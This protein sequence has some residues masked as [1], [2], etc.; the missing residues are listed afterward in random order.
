MNNTKG[1]R[2]VLKNGMDVLLNDEEVTIYPGAQGIVK[3][4]S[5]AWINLEDVDKIVYT[6][7]LF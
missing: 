6:E 7:D 1:L 3:A 5:G 4:A 2:V